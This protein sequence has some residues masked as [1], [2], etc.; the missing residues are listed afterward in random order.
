MNYLEKIYGICPVF[1]QNVAISFKGILNY[2]SRY[3]RK[4]YK[5]LNFLK[6]YDGFTLE[7]KKE[8]QTKE[9]LNFIIYAK[10]NSQF[11][12]KKYSN[13]DVS[14][15]TSISDIKKLPYIEK[16]ELRENI[17]KIVT[18]KKKSVECH[19]GGTTGKSLAVY[20][21]KDDMMKRMATLD[22]FK[23]KAGFINLKMKRATFNG[24]HIVPQ[25]QKTNVFWRYNLSCKQMIF[26]S[27]HISESNLK[28]YVDEL[29]RFKPQSI[30]GFFSSICDVASYIERNKIKLNFTPIAIFPTS[31]TI[32]ETGRNLIEKVF[33][34]QVYNQYASSEGAPFITECKNK[35]LHMQ[36]HSGIFEHFEDENDEVLVTSFTTH[37]TPLIRYRIGDVISFDHNNGGC[38]L[39]G[40]NQPIVK[41]IQGRKFDFLYNAEGVK[42]NSANISNIFKNIPNAIKRAQM[43]QVDRNKVTMFLEVDKKRYIKKYDDLLE[44]EFKAAF[45]NKTIL[46]IKHVECIQ[47]EKSGKFQLIKN[48]VDE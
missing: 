34:C 7:E 25:N 32:T 36:L 41:S 11:Y 38:C 5:Y 16:E 14:K 18:T 30:D 42:I 13:I 43:I 23:S 3:G 27:F 17:D 47:R 26:S 39:C 4:Y 6:K 22:F 31:E 21:T 35:K 45:G 8:Y 29:N 24:K 20:M 19:T 2:F 37:G 28:Y 1:L 48:M 46:E 40:D 10:E 33:K 15:F 9:F 12:K 44:N